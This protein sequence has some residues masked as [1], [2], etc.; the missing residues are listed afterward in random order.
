MRFVM[1]LIGACGCSASTG[2]GDAGIDAS[3]AAIGAQAFTRRGCPDCHQSSGSGQTSPLLGTQV[4]PANI[5]HDV[6]TGIGSWKDEDVER[7]I[8]QGFA[9]GFVPLCSQMA[10]YN[11]MSDDE[12]I[13]IIAFLKSLPPVHNAVPKSV[14]P[15]IKG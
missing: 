7:A 8:R 12:V 14:C 3:P 15:P 10:R 2:P 11:K 4:Y 1:M 13:A 9:P 6:D 5:T